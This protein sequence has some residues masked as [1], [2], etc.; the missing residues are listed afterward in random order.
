MSKRR[1]YVNISEEN[2]RGLKR[3]GVYWGECPGMIL[4]RIAAQLVASWILR[5]E[6]FATW[7]S[8]EQ[9]DIIY[10]TPREPLPPPRRRRD[11]TD[12]PLYYRGENPYPDD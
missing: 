8:A 4:E 5:D 11:I 6:S 9:R 2:Y 1:L 12:E 7:M 10:G 3:L